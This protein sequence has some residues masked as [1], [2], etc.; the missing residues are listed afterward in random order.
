[1]KAMRSGGSQWAGRARHPGCWRPDVI[2]LDLMMPGH[3]WADLSRRPARRR[4]DGADIPVIVLSAAHERAQRAARPAARRRLRQ[5]LRPHRAPGHHRPPDHGRPAADRLTAATRT[6]TSTSN[7]RMSATSP[8][9]A[10]PAPETGQLRRARRAQFPA[11]RADRDRGHVP[12]RQPRPGPGAGRPLPAGLRRRVPRR[13]T[14][15]RALRVRRAGRTAAR[16]RNLR[17]VADVDR[18]AERQSVLR[19]PRPRL[20][21]R[22]FDRAAGRGPSGRWSPRRCWS[23][24]GW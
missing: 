7:Q 2:V 5:A 22:L 6:A 16:D 11:D 18:R 4:P 9:S 17:R 14:G 24:S 1:M 15:D 12:R 20:R 23:G 8:G 21:R 3:G 13:S 10:S 19:A